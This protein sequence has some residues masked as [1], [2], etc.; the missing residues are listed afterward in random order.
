MLSMV[1][2]KKRTRKLYH[3]REILVLD[4]ATAALDNETENLVTEAI[5]SFSGVKTMIII[6]HRLSTIDHCDCVYRIDKGRLVD[7]GDYQTMV[8]GQG[9]LSSAK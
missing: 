9:N 3:Q 1:Y 6:A 2:Q 4:E 8:L 7:S 5:K